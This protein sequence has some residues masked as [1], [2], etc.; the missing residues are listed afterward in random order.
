MI[1]AW[2]FAFGV[3]LAALAVVASGLLPGIY[4]EGRIGATLIV[5][6]LVLGAL[7]ALVRPLLRLFTCPMFA[8]ALLLFLFVL[9]ALMLLGTALITQWL[10]PYTGGYLVVESFGWAVLGGLIIAVIVAL[11]TNLLER[12]QT[13]VPVPP[14]PDMHQIAGVTRAQLDAQFDAIVQPRPPPSEPPQPPQ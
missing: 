9:N 3:S 10:S 1:R 5:A 11:L 7:N 6:G 8:L 12:W 2:L 13:R 4:I 14:P